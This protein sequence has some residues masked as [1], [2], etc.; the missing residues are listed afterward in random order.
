M[1]NTN[2]DMA[3]W[4]QITNI[5][6]TSLNYSN[7]IATDL[8]GN[9]WVL[10]QNNGV[11]QTTFDRSPFLCYDLDMGQQ[12]FPVNFVSSLY[13]PDGNTF[14]LG[15]NPYGIARFDRQTGTTL[16]N[17][18]IPGFSNIPAGALST[19]FSSIIRRSNGDLWFAD[20]NYGIIVKKAQGNAE[21]LDVSNTPWMKENFVNTI[22]E[23]RKH[24]LWIAARWTWL[25]RHTPARQPR[26]L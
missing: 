22:F 12:S 6:G 9:I 19:S 26:H 11:I 18:D 10:T 24:I 23:S 13:T 3:Q 7:S 1:L 8:S 20:N 14:W 21:V 4:Q 5:D 17:H 2:D 15:L 16:F 25:P